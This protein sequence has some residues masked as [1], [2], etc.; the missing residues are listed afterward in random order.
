MNVVKRELGVLDRGAACF[1]NRCQCAAKSDTHGIRRTAA[2]FSTHQARLIHQHALCLG[3]PTVKTEYKSHTQR[4][5]EL[6]RCSVTVE[7]EVL[8]QFGFHGIAWFGAL[9][10]FAS[11]TILDWLRCESSQLCEAGA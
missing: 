1:A 6:G 4:I 3:A 8:N 5:R 9:T 2:P 10:L 11:D 7:A